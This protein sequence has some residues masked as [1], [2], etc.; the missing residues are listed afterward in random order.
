MVSNGS[1]AHFGPSPASSGVSAIMEKL[2]YQE[3]P[4]VTIGGNTFENVPTILKYDD[5]A[6]IS[7]VKEEKLGFTS[8]F[9]IYNWD[10]TYLAKVKGTRV[11][12]TEDGKKAGLVVRDL[13]GVFVCELGKRTAFEIMPRPGAFTTEAE[14]YTPNAYLVKVSD[15]SLAL[16][17]D[18]EKGV[19]IN[20]LTLKGNTFKNM[21]V[22]IWLRSDGQMGLGG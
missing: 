3:S 16:T 17:N 10:G 13:G 4:V 2:Y 14:L 8:Q 9:E 22:G 15:T 6:L 11:W 20:G 12:P 1:V 18:F 5:T 21:R 7:V 19:P